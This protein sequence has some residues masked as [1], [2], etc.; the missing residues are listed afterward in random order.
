M[1]IKYE[2]ALKSIHVKRIQFDVKLFIGNGDKY[3]GSYKESV[4]YDFAF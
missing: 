4:I 3:V 2:F 1:L